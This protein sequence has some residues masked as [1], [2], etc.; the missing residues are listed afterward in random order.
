MNLKNLIHL[1]ALKNKTYLLNAGVLLLIVAIIVV[2]LYISQNGLNPSVESTDNNDSAI[3]SIEKTFNVTWNEITSDMTIGRVASKTYN[4]SI[5]I[6]VYDGSVLGSV[7]V[8]IIWSDDHVYGLL[9][10]K[11]L[12]TLTAEITYKGD[13]QKISS[14]GSGNILFDDFKVNSKPTYTSV[15]A[16]NLGDAIEKVKSNF[17]NSGNASFDTNIR[18]DT[19]EKLWRPLKYLM[20]KGNRFKIEVMYTY[21]IFDIN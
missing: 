15:S 17:S 11:G 18:V 7:N 16:K 19:G 9:K 8:N 20:D 3:T 21:Y 6:S 1:F 14:N 12:D 4:D 5:S 13:T 10:N 2:A